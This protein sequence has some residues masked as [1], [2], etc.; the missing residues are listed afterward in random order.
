MSAKYLEIPINADAATGT[1]TDVIPSRNSSVV[2]T[3]TNLPLG[4]V[5]TISAVGGGNTNYPVGTSLNVATTGGSGNTDC[6][7]DIVVSGGGAVTGITVNNIGTGYV[8][9]DVLVITGGDGNATFQVTTVNNASFPA[10]VSVAAGTGAFTAD[11]VGGS[12]YN[13]GGTVGTIASIQSTDSLTCNSAL[14]PSGSETFDIRKPLQ[15]TSAGATFVARKV[16]VGDIVMNTANGTQTTVTSV[17][18]ETNLLIETDLFAGAG[19]A[20]DAFRITPQL[21]Q[22]YDATASFTTTVT[23][24]DVVE[25]ITSNVSANVVTVVDD[26]RITSTAANIFVNTNSYSVKNQSY[27]ANKLVLI[28]NITFVD[29]VDADTT[30]L[31]LNTVTFNTLTMEHSNQGTGRVVAA[32]IESALIRGSVG[33]DLPEP[34]GPAVALL[35]MPLFEGNQIVVNSLVIS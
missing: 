31:R 15:L 30:V 23:A 20:K 1:M 33:I 35:Q 18:D 24:D 7:V 3:G 12:I 25:N 5:G 4:N 16:L 29:R 11:M 9:T 28:D 10:Q 6:R 27:N 17:I 19:D 26:F 14:F 21:T 13:S 32:A 8:A 2:E 22:I 34:P